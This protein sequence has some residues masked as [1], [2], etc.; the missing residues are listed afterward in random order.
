M[1]PG[2][3]SRRREDLIGYSPSRI[4]RAEQR[5][6][7]EADLIVA[8]NPTVAETW[9]RQGYD[10]VL[11]PFGCDDELFAGTG[12]APLPDDV[13]LKSPI[14]GFVGG[15]V[16]DRIRLDMLDAVTE[17]GHSLL[18]VGPE[19]DRRQG[20]APFE[21]LLARPNVQWVGRQPFERLPSYLRAIDVG[22]VPYADTAFNRGSFPLKTLEYLA[23][24]KPVVSTDLPATRWLDTALVGIESSPAGFANAVEAWFQIA[25]DADL[26]KARQA[27]AHQHSWER[28]A[29]DFAELLL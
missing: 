3:P 26:V 28:R 6:C 17:R 24:G 29:S 4:W 23:A 13:T 12:G 14:A 21:G 2:R 7:K 27:F 19:H 25:R 16:S 10:P 1:G 15:L 20:I 11:I 22:L 9:T 5:R 8:S 18:L